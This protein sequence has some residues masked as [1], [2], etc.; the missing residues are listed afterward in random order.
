MLAHFAKTETTRCTV[1]AGFT[2]ALLYFKDGS[3]QMARTFAKL[4][5]PVMRW[6]LSS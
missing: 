3:Y 6:A 2:Q 4:P 1:N 5:D